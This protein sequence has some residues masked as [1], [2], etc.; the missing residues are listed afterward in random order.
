MR[1]DHGPALYVVTHDHAAYLAW[2]EE[3]GVTPTHG[4]HVYVRGAQTLKGKEGARILF[5]AGWQRRKDWRKVY[6]AALIA[7]R[8]PS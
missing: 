7:Q 4:R 3:R 6:N 2:C 1:T 5:V 8:K